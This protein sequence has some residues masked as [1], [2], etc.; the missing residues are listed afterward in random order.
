M[1]LG[2]SNVMLIR[3]SKPDPDVAPDRRNLT[4]AFKE[5]IH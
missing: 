1:V 3:M 4:I 5:D 2:N